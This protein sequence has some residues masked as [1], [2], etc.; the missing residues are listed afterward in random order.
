MA[1][2]LVV[3][4][5]DNDTELGY[6]GKEECHTVHDGIPGYH[7]RGL[8]VLVY[9]SKGQILLQHRKHRI[10]DS[11]WDLAGST[12]PYHRDGMQEGY[13]EAALR[14]LRT[15]YTGFDDAIVANSSVSIN[16]EAIDPS[17]TTYCENEFCR[18]IIS[19]HDGEIAHKAENAYGYRW[20]SF[21]ELLADVRKKPTSY[22]PW[23]IDLLEMIQSRKPLEL[24]GILPVQREIS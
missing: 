19:L 9:N 4:V 8:T 18:L 11:V 13:E 3:L 21:R 16:Y 14:C 1:D 22:A 5:D 20:S 23:M 24:T 12:H 15:E 17:N 6:R 10:F 2:D 7:H